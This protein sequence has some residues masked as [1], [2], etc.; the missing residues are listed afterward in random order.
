MKLQL[1]FKYR[2]RYHQKDDQQLQN[3][4]RHGPKR[5]QNCSRL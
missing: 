5:L 3:I 2:L 4:G 1:Q